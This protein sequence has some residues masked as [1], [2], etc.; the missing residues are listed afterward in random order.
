MNKLNLIIKIDT[1]LSSISTRER[2]SEIKFLRFW[3]GSTRK[4]DNRREICR[5]F[6]QLFNVKDTIVLIFEIFIK[7]SRIFLYIKYES[8]DGK[9]II[10][11]FETFSP[12]RHNFFY[13]PPTTTHLTC[14]IQTLYLLLYWG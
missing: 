1:F 10:I 5:K 7:I 4:R 11:K 13:H 3:E 8:R 14:S 2:R 12:T 6:S 9:I